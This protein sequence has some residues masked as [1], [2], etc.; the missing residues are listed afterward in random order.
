M[1][2]ANESDN[3]ILMYVL[4]R[5]RT[6]LRNDLLQTYQY[7]I[8]AWLGLGTECNVENEKALRAE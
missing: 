1:T 4:R 7:C 6:A 8:V 2:A 3:S 5:I